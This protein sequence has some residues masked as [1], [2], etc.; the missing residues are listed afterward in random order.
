MSNDAQITIDSAKALATL[1]LGELFLTTDGIL[2]IGTPLGNAVLVGLTG[3]GA[4]PRDLWVARSII[5]PGVDLGYSADDPYMVMN[6]SAAI[7]TPDN[8]GFGIQM[9]NTGFVAIQFL[10][11]AASSSSLEFAKSRSG[12]KGSH[13]IV[14]SGD[15]LGQ[16][17]FEGSD[18]STFRRAAIIRAEVDGTPGSVDMPGRLIFMTSPDAAAT[19]AEVLR[20]DQAK[21]ATFAGAVTITG[22]VILTNKITSYLGTTTAGVGVPPIYASVG[23]TAQTTSIT[24]TNLAGTTSVGRYR[25]SVYIVC[26]TADTL[27]HVV[28]ID[29]NNAG[30]SY[31]LPTLGNTLNS[32]QEHTF[33]VHHTAAS[34]SSIRYSVSNNSDIGNYALYITVE[35][36]A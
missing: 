10:N 18:G 17:T 12:T 6:H 8:G 27:G 31:V 35:N 1:N 21:L 5:M 24:A 7:T 23:L 22:A 28:T 13:T 26:T 33:M 30:I 29:W 19:P 3:I 36:L 34:G 9:V 32:Y 11:L 4:M 25:V 14:Q 20:L 2:W 16:I 15:R